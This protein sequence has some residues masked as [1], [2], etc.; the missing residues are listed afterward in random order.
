MSFL[1]F[2][3]GHTNV[4]SSIIVDTMTFPREGTAETPSFVGVTLRMY[5]SLTPVGGRLSTVLDSGRQVGRHSLTYNGLV[6]HSTLH[7]GRGCSESTLVSGLVVEVTSGHPGT[8]S[9]GSIR[10][11]F[12]VPVITHNKFQ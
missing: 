10:T 1:L 12:D 9:P 8:S 4:M 11:F 5:R 7:L 6:V 2:H 3:N